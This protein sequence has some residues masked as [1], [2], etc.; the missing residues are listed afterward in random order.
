MNEHKYYSIHYYI[1]L[2]HYFYINFK[3]QDSDRCF[4]NAASSR[5]VF[6]CIG[7]EL[8]FHQ[9]LNFSTYSLQLLIYFYFS[10]ESMP[11][12]W[13]QNNSMAFIGIAYVLIRMAWEQEL[14]D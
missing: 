3:G 5:W 10:L 14:Y 1:I 2:L 11:L 7:L 12:F 13:D 4:A 8:P 6:W 9:L